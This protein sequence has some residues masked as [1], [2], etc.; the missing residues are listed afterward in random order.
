MIHRREILDIAGTFGLRPQIVEK[1]YV[2]GWALAGIYQ[3]L[4]LAESRIFKG[5]TCLKKCYFETYR[6]SEDLDFTLS[7]P[8]HIDRIQGARTT[9]QS[10][11]PRFAVEL[12]QQGP[13]VILPTATRSEASGELSWRARVAPRRP[14]SAGWANGPR[15]IYEC[16][17]CGKRFTRKK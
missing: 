15:Y 17:Y 6:F 8:S 5:G 3:P 13:A 14:R 4:A 10:F 7:D 1:D 16:A 2:L 12:S 9:R 11:V